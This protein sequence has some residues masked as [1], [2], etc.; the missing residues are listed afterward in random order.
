MI[1][2]PSLWTELYGTGPSV[3]HYLTTH[4]FGK[5]SDFM[6]RLVN[7]PCCS[8]QRR[9]PEAGVPPSVG[10]FAGR[11]PCGCKTRWRSRRVVPRLSPAV[12]PYILSTSTQICFIGPTS[13]VRRI[14]SCFT[15]GSTRARLTL[16]HRLCACS[17]ESSSRPHVDP[18]LCVKRSA[19][20]NS[21]TTTLLTLSRAADV[22]SSAATA[23]AAAALGLP[24]C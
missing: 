12:S 21:L 17:P 3:Q 8:R 9:G 16:C 14:Q 10:K 15:I 1:S 2:T 6:S 11:H 23:A 4:A 22:S 13:P 24:L 20:L 19:E 5:P 7:R 18:F